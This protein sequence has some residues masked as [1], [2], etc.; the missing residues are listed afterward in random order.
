MA[1]VPKHLLDRVQ[2]REY[3]ISVADYLSALSEK[4]L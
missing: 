2:D 3:L 1:A 4:T